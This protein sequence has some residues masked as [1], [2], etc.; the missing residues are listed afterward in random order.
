MVM[1]RNESITRVEVIDKE[2]RQFVRHDIEGGI[3]LS[4]Q[5]NGKTLK[6]FLDGDWKTDT[7]DKGDNKE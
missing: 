2:G 4:G 5:D 7:K 3:M 1:M 6:I